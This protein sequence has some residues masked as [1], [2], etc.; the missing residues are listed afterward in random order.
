MIDTYDL[1]IDLLET[2]K[3]LKTVK[4][5]NILLHSKYDPIKEAKNFVKENFDEEKTNILF[6]MGLGYIYK[7][8]K[9]MYGVEII[10]IDPLYSKIKEYILLEPE[11]IIDEINK[12]EINRIVN[13]KLEFYSRRINIMC[14][15]SY[16]QLFMREYK[17]T[18]NILKNIQHSNILTENTIR[19]FS[20]QWQENYVQNLSLLNKFDSFNKLANKFTCPI[21]IASGGPSLTKQL[22]ILKKYRENCILIA[23]GSTINSLLKENIF[24]D[25]IVS[26]DGGDANYNHFKS[27][28]IKNSNLIFSFSSHYKIQEEFDGNMYSFLL[29][30]DNSF[31]KYL[32]DAFGIFFP[33]LV[34]GTSVANFALTCAIHMTS[35]P[36]AIIGQ[37][38]AYT[39]NQSHADGNKNYEKINNDLLR[40]KE[41]FKERGYYGEDV[42]TDSLFVAMREEFEKIYAVYGNER[43][44]YNCTEGGLKIENIPQMKF[45]NFCGEYL[46]NKVHLKQ[47][48]GDEIISH[49]FLMHSFFEKEL[50]KYDALIKE[51][52]TAL[53]VLKEEKHQNYFSNN[54]L[55][56]LDCIDDKIKKIQEETSINYILEPILLD[57]VRQPL[58]KKNEDRIEKF[59]K[60]YL[61]NEK[62]Y[63]DYII[64]LE[65]MKN[66][67][68]KVI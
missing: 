19:F 23:S 25:Y 7:E 39:N 33:T 45:K 51:I 6:G 3:G 46:I 68:S 21:V 11:Y 40:K 12:L 15:P 10:V 16:Q 4:I 62:L 67:V 9:E 5:N 65:K 43:E 55:K 37:D 30:D 47:L 41:A 32:Y 49:K 13:E 42:W 22:P 2:K 27:L 57:A 48:T 34:G 8:I 1:K 29:N 58:N 26:V 44:I 18:L 24:P 20:E 61:Q 60:A 35:G 36:I 63:N 54:L 59:K 52:Q 53:I 64:A 17:E 50:E 28:N 31:Q 56:K 66:I 14:A 38:L